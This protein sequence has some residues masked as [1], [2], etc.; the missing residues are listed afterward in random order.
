MNFTNLDF[1][2]A[3]KDEAFWLELLQHALNAPTTF[4]EAFRN[5]RNYSLQ[6][7]LLAMVQCM[8]RNIPIGAINTFKGWQRLGRNVRKDE[9]AIIL[10]MPVNVKDKSKNDDKDA[11]GNATRKIFVPRKNWF[12]YAQTDG[13]TVEDSANQ[14]EWNEAKA[15]SE[16]GISEIPFALFEGNTLGFATGKSFA[17]SPLCDR[18]TAVTFHEVAHIV[19]GHT[20]DGETFIDDATLDNNLQE[21]E[22]ES[23][24]HLLMLLLN[25]YEPESKV[26]TDSRGYIQSWLKSKRLPSSSV[27][28]IL[29]ATNRILKAGM[30]SADS[31]DN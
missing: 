17:V 20:K 23:V 28:H 6:N 11:P 3:S 7:C 22:A 1:N 9:K 14:I 8:F 15:L 19:L 26:I 31:D 18:R 5:F 21:V 12:V 29:S 30:P 25:A 24:A 2:A 27:K 13:A 10:L 16:L 4:N